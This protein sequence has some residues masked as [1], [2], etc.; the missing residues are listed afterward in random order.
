MLGLMRDWLWTHQGMLGPVLAGVAWL[1]VAILLR[2]AW[3]LATEG[4]ATVKR[5]HQIPCA[6]CVYFSED[7]ALKCTVRPSDALSEA[8]IDCP[9]FRPRSS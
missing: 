4:T 3:S 2:S 5:L 9:D 6:G 8:A 7:Y 1:L